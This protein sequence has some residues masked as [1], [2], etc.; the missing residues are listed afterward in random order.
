[1]RRAFPVIFVAVLA[2]AASA[3]AATTPTVAKAVLLPSQVGKGYL[4]ITRSDG[5]G[6]KTRT[7]DLCGTKNYPSE[8][9]RHSRLQVNYLKRKSKLGISNEVVSYKRGGAA[10]AMREVT[11]HATTCPHHKIDPGENKLP[12]LLFNITRLKDGRLIKGYL[13][14]R[15]RVRGRVQGMYHD[16]TAY[17]VYQRLGS[18]LS[19]VY[20]FGPATEAQMLSNLALPFRPWNGRSSCAAVRA[21]WK[22]PSR[23]TMKSCGGRRAATTP[24]GS[25]SAPIRSRAPHPAVPLSPSS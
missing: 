21:R 5:Y 11:L 17:A 24:A 25:A 10:Q 6:L 15:I 18:I 9:L 23:C 13:A 2:L 14:V 4:L 7:L 22:R 3:T 12:P 8:S 20:S 19:G 16:E 1:M